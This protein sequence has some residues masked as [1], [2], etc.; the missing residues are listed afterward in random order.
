[1][2]NE[3]FKD[4]ILGYDL[5]RA[6]SKTPGF[7]RYYTMRLLK[8]ML[9]EHNE[10]NMVLYSN[11]KRKLLSSIKGS[12]D[13]PAIRFRNYLSPK[14]IFTDRKLAVFHSFGDFHPENRRVRKIVS[15]TDFSA[16]TNNSF[17]LKHVNKSNAGPIESL[18]KFD[19][20]VCPSKTAAKAPY[21]LS[22][23]RTKP[24]R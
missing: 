2:D 14:R 19:K 12:L 16:L 7:A 21:F 10:L 4:K 24:I 1:M 15:L 3:I 8:A 11:Q 23:T 6:F 17:A 18:R 13:Y 20:I 22:L 9:D 5:N